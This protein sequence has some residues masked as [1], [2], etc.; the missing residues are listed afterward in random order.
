MKSFVRYAVILTLLIT[1]F[2]AGTAF[3]D[4][5]EPPDSAPEGC[6]TQ[7]TQMWPDGSAIELWSL[8]HFNT[9]T[10]EIYPNCGMEIQYKIDGVVVTRTFLFEGKQPF[11]DGAWIRNVPHYSDD[12]ATVTWESIGH[13]PEGVMLTRGS[14][15]NGTPIEQPEPDDPPIPTPT[16]GFPPGPKVR[17]CYITGTAFTTCL[18]FVINALICEGGF[19][20]DDDTC[21]F[22]PIP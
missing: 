13:A 2:I 20:S 21:H 14:I 11:D 18:P 10:L 15:F 19:T 12:G 3:A 5:V 6:W 17:A 16:P 22:V 4:T 9:E 8:G 1:L 7:D